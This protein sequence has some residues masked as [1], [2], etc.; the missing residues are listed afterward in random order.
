MIWQLRLPRRGVFHTLVALEGGASARV[1]VGI[2]D[3][4]VY[5]ERARARLTADRRDWT[6]LDVDLSPYAGWKWSLFYRPDWIAWRIVLSADALDRT[7]GRVVWGAPVITTD[8]DGARE[9]AR[10]IAAR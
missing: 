4:R 9:Y 7:P 10:R 5:E 6:R 2:S 8:T 3:D 1:R